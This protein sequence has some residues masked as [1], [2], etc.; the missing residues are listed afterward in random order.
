MH[1]SYETSGEPTVPD[2][3][4]RSH[5]LRR[6]AVAAIVLAGCA[7]L[8][9]GGASASTHHAPKGKKTK[10]AKK[11]PSVQRSAGAAEDVTGTTIVASRDVQTPLGSMTIR[12]LANGKTCLVGP[13]TPLLN[14]P[15][16]APPNYS[17]GIVCASAHDTAIGALVIA[18]FRDI[19]DPA[20][21]YGIAPDGVSSFTLRTGGRTF[22][23]TVTD[24]IW[25]ATNVPQTATLL[26]DAAAA[27]RAAM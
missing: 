12:T 13:A 19:G 14:Q 4:P 5:R 3:M 1:Q 2:A 18:E 23:V 9:V 8:S 27:A 6:T 16:G 17:H 10:K 7:T 21:V 22:P 15:A 25:T 24:G 11:K 26:P 20:K